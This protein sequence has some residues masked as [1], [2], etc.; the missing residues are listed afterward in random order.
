VWFWDHE[1]EPGGVE[2]AR[3]IAAS[4]EDFVAG[5]ESIEMVEKPTRLRRAWIDPSLLAELDEA[6]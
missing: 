2:P 5:L 6:D 3:R 4:F 1:L